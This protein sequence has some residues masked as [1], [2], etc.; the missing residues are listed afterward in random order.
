MQ[1]FEILQV[2][3]LFSCLLVDL[4]VAELDALAPFM[5]DNEEKAG[6]LVVVS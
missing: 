4:T 3:F 6:V 1:Y 2:A 5:E